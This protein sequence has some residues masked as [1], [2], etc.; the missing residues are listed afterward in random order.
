V[1]GER[2]WPKDP[3]KAAL[4]EGGRVGC[5]RDASGANECPGRLHW[6]ICHSALAF[7]PGYDQRL[8]V[9]RIR[10]MRAVEEVVREVFPQS[11]RP[12]CFNPWLQSACGLPLSAIDK[13]HP[14]P[15][16]QT[17][18]QAVKM[19]GPK[20]RLRSRLR[21]GD[22]SGFLEEQSLIHAHLSGN[23][24]HKRP[25]FGDQM[26]VCRRE[27][28]RRVPEVLRVPVVEIQIPTPLH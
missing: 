20:R 24:V 13:P 4:E 23:I 19:D 2:I 18:T 26:G 5:F 22:Q 1:K 28:S 21:W 11:I 10:Q 14:P 3:K 27:I 15:Q 17:A 12:P 8:V 25:H 7:T 9:G 16:P 6:P